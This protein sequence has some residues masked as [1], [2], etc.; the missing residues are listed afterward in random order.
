MPSIATQVE[1]IEAQQQ[2]IWQTVGITVT[3]AFGQ[4]FAISEPVIT[5]GNPE[6]MYG[7]LAIQGIV[8]QFHFASA[9]DHT[10]SVLIPADA[11]LDLASSLLDRE[12]ESL[13]DEL[14]GQLRGQFESI[15]QGLCV[16]I[17]NLRHQPYIAS[18]TTVRHAMYNYPENLRNAEAVVRA[19]A[20]WKLGDAEGTIIWLFDA[21]NL[22]DIIGAQ[23]SDEDD[24]LFET[25]SGGSTNYPT[26][27]SSA[28]QPEMA[29]G[30]DPSLEIL[31]DI[32]LDISVELGRVRMQVK[33]VVDLGAGS[34]VELDRAAGE[35]V[36]VLVN[37][38]V[39][40]RGEVVVIEDNFG[41]R[42]TEILTPIER[43][44]KLGERD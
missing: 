15:V 35:P 37:G 41:I 12:V 22:N 16:G 8:I 43:L 30:I 13:D 24:V 11:A 2:T 4:A 32:P 3:E 19:E 39:V 10:Q 31:L 28:L 1:K 21:V 23:D 44:K 18:G 34:I 9:P 25:F 5:F 7:L 20:K 17:S 26:D 6:E 29:P 42:V 38:R 36:D 40:A 14:L 33:E 27:G